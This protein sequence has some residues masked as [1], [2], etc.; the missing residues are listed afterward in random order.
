MRPRTIDHNDAMP[1][2]TDRTARHVATI[3]VAVVALS[4]GVGA[5]SSDDGGSS[6]PPSVPGPSTPDPTTT[7]VVAETSVEPTT[8]LPDT[9]LADEVQFIEISARLGIGDDATVVALA[10]DTETLERIP[11][12]GPDVAPAWCTGSD[13]SLAD[14]DRAIPRYLVR[15]GAPA[16]DATLAGAE[17]FELETGRVRVGGGPVPARFDLTVDGT[18]H[19]VLAGTMDLGESSVGGTFSGTTTDGLEIE[20]AF[21][22]G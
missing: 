14:F 13:A 10:V 12:E 18:V 19:R 2:P 20:G 22:C 17:R 15:V 9:P 8:T 11:A 21:L 1:R 6:V 7:T 16:V 5:C 3:V 4:L